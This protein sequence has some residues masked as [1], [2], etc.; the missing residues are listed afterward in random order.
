MTTKNNS[1][2]DIE[3]EF[4]SRFLSLFSSYYDVPSTDPIL[5]FPSVPPD[6][7]KEEVQNKPKSSLSQP[8]SSCVWDVR[9]KKAVERNQ[10]EADEKNNEIKLNTN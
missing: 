10:N 4:Y 7:K 1:S 5:S 8:L 6:P 9:L 2:K 3:S